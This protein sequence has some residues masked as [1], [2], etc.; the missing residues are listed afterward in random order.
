MSAV[1]L[2]AQITGDGPLQGAELLIRWDDD[3][4]HPRQNVAVDV[5]LDAIGQHPA[6]WV[7]LTLVGAYL[8]G[9]PNHGDA[10]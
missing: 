7:P 5:H 2:K 6:R 10:A 8:D 4:G 1:T 9:L 3:P